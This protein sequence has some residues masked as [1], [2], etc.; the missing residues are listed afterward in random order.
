[1]SRYLANLV[2]RA[3]GRG[4]WAAVSPVPG[5]GPLLGLQPPRQ[6][7]IEPESSP[8]SAAERAPT[9]AKEA[10]TVV[11]AAPLTSP[12]R[13]PAGPA[14][15]V[16]A[17]Q[18]DPPP[19]GD[20][21]ARIESLD[22]MWPARPARVINT[23]IEGPVSGS[24]TGDEPIVGPAI[25]PD[26]DPATR[27]GHPPAPRGDRPS[28]PVARPEPAPDRS[29]APAV[30]R[31]GSQPAVVSAR[32]AADR[33]PL[34]TSA[35]TGADRDARRSDE[36]PDAPPRAT[37]SRTAQAPTTTR[38]SPVIAEPPR[39]IRPEFTDARKVPAD[40]GATDRPILVPPAPPLQPRRPPSSAAP[41][42]VP[43]R[44]R[45]PEPQP[46]PT[47]SPVAALSRPA[48]PILPKVQVR[49]GKVEVR[50]A[51]ARQEQAPPAAAPRPD[52]FDDYLALRSHHRQDD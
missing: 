6:P 23:K 45:V 31:P 46:S 30:A 14:S 39:S 47:P 32:P 16:Q 21:A 12:E 28:A 18:P 44:V 13:D 15:G 3:T 10:S 9:A 1:M 29:P 38:A 11:H 34:S 5:P 50:P 42:P 41:D 27:T 19:H 7:P 35:G 52:G 33:G 20:A 24:R 40:V 17:A 4:P 8:L 25:R 37:P 49:I 22:P 26:P 48:R 43:E 51:P 2:R 36:S